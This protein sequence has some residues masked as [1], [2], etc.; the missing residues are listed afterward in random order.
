MSEIIHGHFFV[1]YCFIA[2]S[3]SVSPERDKE[4]LW[5]K[6]LHLVMN[7]SLE[8]VTF[9]KMCHFRSIKWEFTLHSLL[10]RLHASFHG[11]AH[12]LPGLQPRTAGLTYSAKVSG[13]GW[14]GESPEVQLNP[15]PF[16]AAEER[17]LYGTHVPIGPMLLQFTKKALLACGWSWLVLFYGH[18]QTP[19]ITS[20]L[21]ASFSALRLI[22]HSVLLW[23]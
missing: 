13:K 23:V 2:W 4:A 11:A 3:H 19:V 12:G 20:K 9:H 16:G 15:A 18:P 7:M 22:F 6:K 5:G 8:D 21:P 1:P 10:G 14:A 17:C